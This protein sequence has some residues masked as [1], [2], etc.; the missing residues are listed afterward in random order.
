[1]GSA[2]SPTSPPQGELR[3]MRHLHPNH[4]GYTA[5]GEA[6]DLSVFASHHH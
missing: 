5:M 6:I 4:A 1:M 2:G 3:V